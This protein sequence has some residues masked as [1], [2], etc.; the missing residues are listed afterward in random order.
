LG[1]IP[2]LSAFAQADMAITN[3]AAGD[4]IITKKPNKES[5]ERAPAGAYRR[6][7]SACKNESVLDLT[8]SGLRFTFPLSVFSFALLI[9][10]PGRQR[11]KLSL[12]GR[13]LTRKEINE[14]H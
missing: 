5:V 10:S 8:A 2:R 13:G 9:C 14:V 1:V 11:F 12:I 4:F 6:L 3:A 7:R